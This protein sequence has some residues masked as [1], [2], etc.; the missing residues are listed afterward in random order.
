[1]FISGEG[2]KGGLYQPPQLSKIRGELKSLRD[3]VN[4][5]LDM[6]EPSHYS[7]AHPGVSQDS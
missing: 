5:L 1:M 4:Q 2:G 6:M 7:D 3:H